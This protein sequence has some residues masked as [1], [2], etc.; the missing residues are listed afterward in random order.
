[1]ADGRKRRVGHPRKHDGGWANE[2][3]RLNVSNDTFAKWR[4][5][6]MV[7]LQTSL[8][9][10]CYSPLTE[11]GLKRSLHH[12]H[13]CAITGLIGIMCI[14]CMKYYTLLNHLFLHECKD[15]IPPHRPFKVC[16]EAHKVR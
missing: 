8:L 9:L 5:T 11:I 6:C 3:Q 1:M 16:I 13:C 12:S 7:L 14:I 10:F 4:G 2:H 15:P